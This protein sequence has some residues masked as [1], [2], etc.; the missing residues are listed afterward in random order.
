MATDAPKHTPAADSHD[1]T[2]AIARRAAAGEFSH[3]H[4]DVT[5]GD[6]AW[7]ALDLAGYLERAREKL[8]PGADGESPAGVAKRFMDADWAPSD[9]EAAVHDALPG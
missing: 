4:P 5:P 8:R 7:K 1:T 3:D 2:D 6:D 9:H